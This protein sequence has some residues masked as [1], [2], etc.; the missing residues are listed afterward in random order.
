M[1]VRSGV[2]EYCNRVSEVIS[3]GESAG[4]NSSRYAAI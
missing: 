3:N 2:V 1:D 4:R